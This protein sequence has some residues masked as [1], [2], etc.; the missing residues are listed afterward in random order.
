MRPLLCATDLSA[1][2]KPAITVAAA[3]ARGLGTRLELT[4]VVHVPPGLPPELMTGEVI[5]DLVAAAE[6]ELGRRVAELAKQGVDVVGAV[7]TGLVDDCI[8]GRAGEMNAELLILGTHARHGVARALVGGIAERAIRWSSCPV[9]VVPPHGKARLAEW[10]PEQRPLKVVAAIDLSIAS[11][12]ALTWLHHL[13]ANARCDL[14]LLHIYDLPRERERLGL[15]LTGTCEADPDVGEVLSRDLRHRVAEQLGSADEI[16]LRL[17]PSLG[18]EH[19]PLADE[20]ASDDADLLV[21]GTSQ[22][23]RGSMAIATV[24]GARLPVLCVPARMAP[25]SER[26]SLAPV[27]RLMVTTD[28][29]PAAEVA[30]PEAYRLL[31]GIGG[32]VVLAHITPPGVGGLSPESR[33]ELETRLLGLVPRG[34]DARGIYTRTFVAESASPGEA[35]VQAIRRL[36]PD[37]V[38]MSSHG[39][40]SLGRALHGSVAEHVMR[41]SPKPVLVVPTRDRTPA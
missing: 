5:R 14:R 8:L 9:L 18:A 36:D 31:A 12:A 10:R 35:L 37:I 15:D 11:D 7:Q 26:P 25:A 20:A 23:G 41:G 2:S 30:I 39:R 33:H 13:R 16:P 19:N 40:S 24:R 28:F 4:H 21:V 34:A 29:S 32:T 1:S 38:V 17:R 3:L 22:G 27:R 6:S